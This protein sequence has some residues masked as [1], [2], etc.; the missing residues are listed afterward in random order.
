MITRVYCIGTPLS[1]RP[2]TTAWVHLVL[3]ARDSSQHDP[4]SLLDAEEMDAVDTHPSAAEAQEAQKKRQSV[5][6]DGCFEKFT[7]CEQLGTSELWYC[8]RCKT[9][10]QVREALR[11]SASRVCVCVCGSASR[12]CVC[13][14]GCC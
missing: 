14:L 13:V 3:S 10:R 9:H 7:E 8:S 5:P 6:I 11:A 12:V 4:R 1:S 2:L